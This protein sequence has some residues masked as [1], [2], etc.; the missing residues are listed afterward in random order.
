MPPG[1]NQYRPTDKGINRTCH[2]YAHTDMNIQ[3][4]HTYAQTIY[5]HMYR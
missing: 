4:T 1:P 2:V 3:H 5:M